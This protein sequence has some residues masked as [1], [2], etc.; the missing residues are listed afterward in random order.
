MKKVLIIT[1]C[2]PPCNAI[3]SHRPKSFADHFADHGLYPIIVTRHWTGDEKTWIDYQLPNVAPPRVTEGERATVIELPY[4]GKLFARFNRIKHIAPLRKL[5]AFY[6]AATGQFQIHNYAVESFEPFMKDYLAKN[7]VDYI[8]ATC[9]PLSIAQVGYRLARKFDVPLIVDFRDLWNNEILS[10]DYKPTLSQKL[11]D[12]FYEFHLARWIR[13][14]KLV[15]AVTEPI[16][17]EVRRIVPGMKTLTVTNGFETSLFANLN[18]NSPSRNKRFTFSIIGTL[19]PEH[20][21][22]VLADGMDRFLADKNLEDVQLNL[23]GTA[24]IP[25]IKSFFEN[26]FPAACTRLTERIPRE[27][28][29]EIMRGSDVLCHVGWRNYRGIASG[30]VFEYMGARKNVI[31]APGDNDIMEELVTS[32]GVGSA[33]NSAEEFAAKMNDWFAEWRQNGK[34]EWHGDMN[35]IMKYSRE[36]QARILAEAILG[37]E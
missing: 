15:T 23:I 20:D 3:S 29:L 6:L 5:M 13:P 32:T 7:P 17:E 27:E 12:F 16:N 36:N 25:E 33:A 21:L 10:S 11:N 31:I 1:Y 30:K 26:R 19:L 22:S 14:A 24:G 4:E 34:L 37:I 28:A 8:F 9:D 35:V 2:Y 18:G